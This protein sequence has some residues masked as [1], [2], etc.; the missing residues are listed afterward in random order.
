MESAETFEVVVVGGGPCGLWLACELKSAG[1]SVCVLERRPAP[2]MQSRSLTIH[3]RTLEMFGLRG[4]DRRF[5]AEGKPLPAWHFAGLPVAVDFSGFDSRYPFMLFIPQTKTEGLLLEH[6]GELGVDIRRGWT[7]H[8]VVQSSD[9]CSITGN[10]AKSAFTMN[11]SYVIGADGARSLVRTAAGITFE[12]SAPTM[13]VMMADAQV[14]FPDGKNAASI[15]NAE[16]ALGFFPLGDGSQRII[17]LDPRRSHVD[18]REPLSEEEMRESIARIV[19]HD[20]NVRNFTWLT[21]FDDETRIAGSYRRDRYFLVGDAAHVHAPMG[22]QGLNVG[23]QDAM[24]LGWKIAAVIRDGAPKS[25][26]DTYEAERRPIGMRLAENT[27]AQVALVSTHNMTP[28]G[29]ALRRTLSRFLLN[30]SLNREIAGELS[31]F[32][33]SYPHPIDGLGSAANS[34]Q[35]LIGTR[36][37]DADVVDAHGRPSSI[38]RGLL[39]GKWL[40]LIRGMGAVPTGLPAW[41]KP[42]TLSLAKRTEGPCLEASAVLVRPDGYVA[43]AWE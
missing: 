3:G 15:E 34:D 9:G 41:F 40:L 33:L 2:I 22:G 39:A 4:L 42:N 28:S 14:D 8:D 21:R 20:L 6:A 25:L 36:M 35:A 13:S 24:N 19:G 38:Y 26:L 27:L 12:G 37:P 11:A 1:V 31:G 10:N 18:R 43:D 16:G 23:L 30:I 17:R 7:A 29:Q 32:D 5:L